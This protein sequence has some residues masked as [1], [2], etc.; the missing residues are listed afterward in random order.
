MLAIGCQLGTE[1]RRSS[2]SAV[3]KAEAEL[4]WSDPGPNAIPR[5]RP[6]IPPQPR[7]GQI[8][9]RVLA[10]S[11]NPIDVK[12]A[13]GYGQRLF[14]LIGAAGR[15]LVLGNDFVGE[16]LLTGAN[17]MA[18]KPGDLVFGTVPTGRRGGA[19]RSVLA[20]DAAL[21][22]KLPVD[23]DPASAS[24]LPYTFCTLW[25]A[26]KAVGLDAHS[27]VGKRVLIQGGSSALGQLATQ[28][29]SQWGAQVTVV[30]SQRHA[31]LCQALGATGIVDRHA[32]CLDDLPCDFDATLNFGAWEDDA[33]LVRRLAPNALGHATAVHPLVGA[34][35]QYGWFKGGLKAL[36]QWRQMKELTRS[37]GRQVHYAWTLFKPDAQ[38]LNLLTDLLSTGRIKLDVAMAV[39]FSQARR[40]FE[41]VAKGSPARAVLFPDP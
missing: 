33:P 16:V 4:F 24:V 5:T 13:R 2:H 10:T 40:A 22:R 27:A 30:T 15:E 23:T 25:Q 34:L 26:L 37:R 35:D 36:H 17:A 9:L 20:V 12:R 3:D 29:L 8:L 7:K 41:H 28:L 14:R 6:L 39:P 1:Y 21:A 31:G 38:A 11:V 32:Q 18:F 19:H